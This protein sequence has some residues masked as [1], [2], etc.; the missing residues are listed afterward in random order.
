MIENKNNILNISALCFTYP[1]RTVPA[2]SG[3][4]LTVE[5]GEFLVLCGRSGCGKTTLLRQLKPGMAPHGT[6]SGDIWFDGAPL[7]ALS[8]RD[9]AARIAFVQQSPEDQI[10]TDQV[11]HELAFGLE[12][13]GY[14]SAVIRRRVAEMAAFFGIESWFHRETAQLSGGQKQLLN[15]AAVMTLQPDVLILDEPTAQLDPIA[16]SEFLA[17]LGRIHREL[18]TTVI[19]T[20]HRLEEVLP[21]ATRVAVME[22]GHILCCDVPT[23]VGKKLLTEDRGMFRAMPDAMRIWAASDGHSPCPVSVEEGRRWL[24]A[25]AASRPMQ[26]VPPEKTY[27]YADETVVQAEGVWFRYEKDGAD[28]LKDFALAVQKGEF[29]ALMGGNGAGKTTA[30]KLLGGLLTPQRG[31]IS[32]RGKVGIL[33]QDPQTIFVKK[34][35]RMDLEE[36]FR[37]SDLPQTVQ[38][39]RLCRVVALCQLS[40]LLERHPYDLSG[41]EQQR[42]ALA[43]VLLTEPEIL[44]LDEPTK[45]LDADFRDALGGI[46]QRL[47]DRGMTIVMVSHDVSFC[48]SFAHRCAMLFDG[49]VVTQDRTRAFFAGNRFYTTA[50]N[51]MARSLLPQAVTVNDVIAACGGEVPPAKV[52]QEESCTLP[53]LPPQEK[54]KMPLWRK[55]LA[56]AAGLAALLVLIRCTRQTDLSALVSGGGLTDRGWAALPWYGALIA[57]LAVLAAALGHPTRSEA[58]PLMPRRRTARSVV[59]TVCILLLIPLTL[60]VGGHYLT[61]RKYYITSLLM[62][63]E[64][65]APF[66]IAF[67]GRKPHARELVTVAVLCAIGVAGRAALFMVPFF[68][69]MLA[70]TIIAGVGLGGETG[71]LV[72]A[73]TMLV[74]NMIFSQG[75]WTP[76]QM[77][78]MGIIGFLAGILFRKRWSRGVLCVFGGLSAIVIYGGLM[79]LSSALTWTNDIHLETVLAYCITGFPVDCVHAAATVIFLWF[80]AVPMLDKLRRIRTKYGLLECEQSAADGRH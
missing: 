78:S 1:G 42:A 61:G 22:R 56:I 28:V 60:F 48:A 6:R 30:L 53:P 12:N 20:A 2:L 69:P 80:G 35:V 33:P 58:P 72:G 49:G 21:L 46:L 62:L 50:A 26:P 32:C 10:V 14:D 71:F 44:L 40:E 59:A 9:G 24:T 3:V 57:S 43:K 64:C 15:L 41:G 27:L 51:R 31:S 37:G 11:W 52:H 47:S 34:T 54:A 68:K 23:Q 25:F 63:L 75:P 73:M 5:R 29:L 45:G 36:V 65:M 13:L 18:G 67:E 17:V 39:E 16:A 7:A 55:V 19:M 70:L 38:S 66:F 79:N 76:W 74:S 8:P 77:F 4:E